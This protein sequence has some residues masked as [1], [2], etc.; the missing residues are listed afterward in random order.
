MIN[1]IE[2]L[3]HLNIAVGQAYF[4]IS[5]ESFE[6]LFK[7]DENTLIQLEEN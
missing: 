7:V 2:R 5:K 6:R 1:F 3:T 4:E